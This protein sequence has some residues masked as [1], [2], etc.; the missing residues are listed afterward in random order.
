MASIQ[1]PPDAIRVGRRCIE[2]LDFCE[3]IKD[4][5]WDDSVEKW[6]IHCRITIPGGNQFISKETDWFV[7]IDEA[8]PWGKI[9][10]FPGK[11]NGIEVTFQH[12]NYNGPGD[13]TLPWRTGNIC[14]RT[15]WK[16]LKRREYGPEPISKNDRL[17]WN[18]QRARDWL[19]KASKNQLVNPGDPFE[20]P[21]FPICSI[22]QDNIV[23]F[24]E[25]TKSLQ[26]WNKTDNNSGIAVLE[27]YESVPNHTFVKTFLSGKKKELY[28]PHFGNAFLSKPKLDRECIWIK[29]SNLPIIPP[30]Q[31][32]QSWGELKRILNK[33]N[34]N[35]RELLSGLLKQ[36]RDGK[37]HLMLIG[38][39]IPKTFGGTC[40]QMHWQPL[41][42]PILS[43]KSEKGFSR[44]VEKSY[45]RRDFS[46]VFN[47]TK[48]LNWSYSENWHEEQIST[49]GRYPESVL[50]MR[51]ALIGAGA[52][53]SMFA[54]LL[55]RSGISYLE[56]IDNDILEV[57]NLVRHTLDANK[58]G[59][60]KAEAL[61][62]RLNLTNPNS[63]VNA[64]NSSFSIR[65]KNIIKVL[66]QCHLIVDCTANDFV[67]EQ[68]DSFHW[69]NDKVFV[70]IST[71]MFARRLFIYLTRGR[72]FD[73]L[74]FRGAAKSWLD[75]EKE[76]FGENDFPWEGI[77]CWH[78]VFPAR[79]DD[80]WLMAAVAS[81][82]L[83]DAIEQG[84]K[85]SRLMVFE[86]EIEN[87]RFIGIK[88]VQ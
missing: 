78:P 67:I 23:V 83:V 7:L 10:F 2:E 32:P 31:V 60:S 22:R 34:I 85:H 87:N 64:H 86:Q 59:H 45:L 13:S 79:A 68:L 51:I 14:C 38:F 50:K 4:F 15:P 84:I 24:S 71:G 36:F 77:G 41:K 66:E 28:R 48:T 16:Q 42:M 70:S 25:D 19:I 35:F 82:A 21:H 75:K 56:I 17:L 27:E 63:R 20:L 12:Q 6:V 39:P 33:E 44:T 18:F 52:L 53:G 8:Y 1:I 69:E 3:L 37:Q 80:L 54:E 43:Y 9:D 73:A 81:K 72:N 26:L 57:G 11:G 58:I 55:V 76:E 29:I 46:I 65:D 47:E 5:E 62:E 61:A 40:E 30:W 74:C 49:R 88:R